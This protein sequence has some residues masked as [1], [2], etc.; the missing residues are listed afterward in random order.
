MQDW[1]TK[2][3]F[4]NPV[5]AYL[6]ALGTF[7]LGVL[8]T[9]VIQKLVIHRVKR[10]SRRTNTTLDDDLIK[11]FERNLIP[12]VYLGI[13]YLSLR[14][15]TISPIVSRTIDVIGVILLT[16]LVIRL[17]GSLVEYSLRLYWFTHRADSPHLEQSLRALIPAIKIV[18]WAFGVVFLLDNFGFDISAIVA[19]L[20]IGGVAIALAS[21]GLLQDLFSYFS[22]LFDRPFEIGD[23]IIVGD[24]MGAVEYVG[25]KTTRIRS[26]G[27]EELILSNTDL[28]SSRLRN[29]K[30]MERRRVVFSIGV[31]Y[32]TGIHRLKAIPEVIQGIIDATE[33]AEFDRAHFF[34]FGDFSLNFEVVYYVLGN[35]Y[36]LY[37]NIQQHINLEI[38]Q[39]LESRGIEFA[40]PTQLLY[41][42]N[43]KVSQGNGDGPMATSATS[44]ASGGGDRQVDQS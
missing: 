28:T 3:I 30:R 25:I 24:F 26:L 38:K 8:V 39:Q 21:Q 2:E 29:Y 6:I 37:M 42:S 11:I 7:L 27:G 36:N 15:L 13:F 35:D 34:S 17:L 41:L 20:G 43:L 16:L 10:W 9:K 5:S 4:H 12:L 31:T 23:F 33:N 18:L 22:I 19:G 40:Y 14:D 1:L 32:E 44:V